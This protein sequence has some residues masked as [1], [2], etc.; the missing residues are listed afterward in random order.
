MQRR[1]I[2]LCV[3]L[4]AA[5]FGTV[6]AM[7]DTVIRSVTYSLYFGVEAPAP[8]LAGPSC[9]G[10]G[11]VGWPVAA[12]P[13]YPDTVNIFHTDVEIEFDGCLPGGIGWDLFVSHDFPFDDRRVDFD[14]ALIYLNQFTRLTLPVAGFEFTGVDIGEDL[15]ILPQANP[16]DALWLGMNSPISPQVINDVMAEWTPPGLG[17]S[18]WTAMRLRGVA[19]DADDDGAFDDDGVFSVWQNSGPGQ[20]TIQMSSFDDGVPGNGASSDGITDSDVFFDAAPGHSHMNWGF[21][22]PGIYRIDIQMETIVSADLPIPRFDIDSDDDVDLAD[23]AEF[24]RCFGHENEPYPCGC[25]W[26]DGDVDGD[27]DIDDYGRFQT[28]TSG[29]ESIADPACNDV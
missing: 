6:R 4:V 25:D 13:Q 2:Q 8:V 23:F 11:C 1:L 27:V 12:H 9:V 10:E 15:W 21:S 14:E 28:C 20:I 19:H 3:V 22:A 16:A 26:A 17:P 5:H 24:Q 18:K 7:G 29:A